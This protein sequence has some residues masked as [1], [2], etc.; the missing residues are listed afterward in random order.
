MSVL[1]CWKSSAFCVFGLHHCKLSL[2]VLYVIMELSIFRHRRLHSGECAGDVII[3]VMA[4]RCHPLIIAPHPI[5]SIITI[6]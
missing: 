3:S 2:L 1:V 5:F 6:Y 4:Q